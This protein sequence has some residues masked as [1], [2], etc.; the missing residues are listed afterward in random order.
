MSYSLALSSPD[1]PQHN[2]TPLSSPL[3][4]S[5]D[6]TLQTILNNAPQ[7]P[8]IMNNYHM[9]TRAKDGIVKKKAFLSH[10]PTKP[11]TFSQA[12]KSFY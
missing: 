1:V 10:M 3:H 2:P 4:S 9:I 12:I 5:S 6:H 8:P 11:A 7:H